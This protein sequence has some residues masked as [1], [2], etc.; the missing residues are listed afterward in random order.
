MVAALAF[1]AIGCRPTPAQRA[2]VAVRIEPVAPSTVVSMAKYSG[3]VQAQTQVDLAFRAGGYLQSLALVKGDGR[4]HRF[5]SRPIQSGDRVSQGQVLATLRQSDFKQ[6]LSEVGGMSTEAAASYRKANDDLRRAKKLLAESAI[7][8][9]EYD[10]IKSRHDALAGEASAAAAR[11]GQA[12]LAL[13]DSELKSPLDG[14]VLERRAEVGTLVSPGVPV[15]T[16]AD[17]SRVKV[18]FGV[19]DSVQ[20]GLAL[21]AEVHVTTDAARERVFNAVITKIAAQADTKTRIFDVEASIDNADGLLKVGLVTNIE[22]GRVLGDG[23][24]HDAPPLLIPLSA[25]VKLRPEEESFWV[26]LVSDENGGPVVHSRAV[27]LGN[28]VGNRVSVAK[29]LTAGDRLVIQG[30][31]LVTEG[32]RVNVVPGSVAGGAS[33]AP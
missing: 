13:S 28:L 2:P 4:D 17:T 7:S 27:E 8:Q 25:I 31:T 5:D 9:A 21:G 23:G 11:V 20:R 22:V 24:A 3:T 32:Q 1:A 6:R 33:G 15:L 14:I 30:A 26:F 19:P 16:V 29:G 10:A 12:G 18:V